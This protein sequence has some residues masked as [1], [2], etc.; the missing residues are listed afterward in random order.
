MS[1]WGRPLCWITRH[2]WLLQ[3]E[4]TIALYEEN[5]LPAESWSYYECQRCGLLIRHTIVNLD[6]APKPNKP[7]KQ[8]EK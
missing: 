6:N 7:I 5:E 1:I 2:R 8:G 3:G 4:Q